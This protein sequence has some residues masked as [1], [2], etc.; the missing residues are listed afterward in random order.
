MFKNMKLRNKILIPVGLLVLTVFVLM[1]FLMLSHVD[2]IFRDNAFRLAEETAYRYG[3]EVKSALESALESARTISSTFEG[4]KKG[5]RIPDREILNQMLRHMLV[6]N[7]DFLGVWTCWEPYALDGRDDE[8]I[9]AE[10]HDHSGRYMPL[11]H[12]FS[13]EISLR[14][15]TGFENFLYT[16]DYMLVKNRGEELIS[17]PR[18][19]QN[20]EPEQVCISLATPVLHN[21]KV[22]AAAGIL[23][24]LDR[25][26]QPVYRIRPLDSGYISVISNSGI[27]VTHPMQEITGHRISEYVPE[28]IRTSLVQAVRR[29]E[30]FAFFQNSMNK[31][32][33]RD[34]VIL[35]P[36]PIGRT[37]TP[38]SLCVSVP[39]SRV[40]EN[41]ERL[42]Y[43]SFFV[44]SALLLSVILIVFFLSR[45]IVK[46]L[47]RLVSV[48]QSLADGNFEIRAGLD[49]RDE[50]GM[51]ARFI[52]R[53]FDIVVDKMYWYEGIVDAIPFPISVT[54]MDTRWTFINKKAEETV[55]RNRKEVL[56]LQCHNRNGRICNTN[57]CGIVL[58]RKG[59]TT[60]LFE[61]TETDRHYQIDTAWLRNMKGEKNGHVEIVQEITEA[62][63][64]KKKADERNWVQ[65]GES[66]F[67]HLIRG[68]QD[69]DTLGRNMISFLCKYI[70]AHV[71]VL[72]L[73]DE[74][75]EILKLRASYAYKKRKELS[76]EIRS[77]E[78]IAGQS[79]LEKQTIVLRNVPEDYIQV[80][81]GLGSGKPKNILVSP[82]LFDEE[83]KGV[84]EI[85]AFHEF[86][87][88]EME[89]VENIVRHIGVV[90]NTAQSRARMEKLLLQTQTQAEEL[91]VQQEELRQANEELEEQTRALKKSESSLQQ[92]QEELRVI[93][94][95]L[96]ERTYDL[97][98]QRDAIEKKNEALRDAH[99]EIELKARDLEIASKYK[100]EFLANMSHELRTPLNSILILSQL[101][102]DNRD[103]RLSPK[104]QEFAETIHSSGSDLLSL[105]NDILD[106]SKVE[107]G[108]LEMVIEEMNLVELTQDVRRT[109]EQV[110]EHKGL[111]LNVEM[112]NDL[113]PAIHTDVKRVW[114]I[115][116]NLLSNAFKF[117]EKGGVT[118]S[119]Y[120]PEPDTVFPVSGLTPENAL[121]FAVSDTGIGIPKD[122]QNLIFQAFQQADGTTSRKY[123]GTGLGLSISR[124]FAKALGGEIQ[125]ESE[126]DKGSSFILFLPVDPEGFVGKNSS[127][128]A[129]SPARPH[130]V[131]DRKPPLPNPDEPPPEFV[132][133]DR[134]HI[135]KGDKS[136]L[137]IEDDPN[138][139]RILLE[140][141]HERGF[142]V[143]VAEDGETGL[144]FADFYRPSG[145]ILDIA[146]PG[147]DGWSVMER[148]KQNPELRHIP[149]YFISVTD[150][151]LDALRLGAV[152]FLTKPVSMEMLED[153]FCRI[154][155]IVS[156][157]VKKLLVVED[158]EVQKK[159]I[160]ELVSGRDV[161]AVAVNT[162]EA[163]YEYLHRETV[164]CIILD[165]GLGDMSGYDFLATIRKNRSFSRIPVIV[166]TGRDISKDEEARLQKYA[167]SIIVKGVRSPERLLEETALFLHRVAAALPGEKRKMISAGHEKEDIFKDKKILIVDDDMRNVFALASVLEEKGMRIIE[168]RNG[169]ES[170]EKLDQHTDTDLVIMDIM[171]P[172]M[173]GYEAI[174][175]I[176]EDSRFKKLPIIA[177]TAK[178]M[179]GD[180]N[181][182]VEA[183]AN[184]YLAKPVDT[185]RL[186][187]LLRVWLY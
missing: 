56:G 52:D 128:K 19:Y 17:D 20:G 63:R 94:E 61:N 73:W 177:L 84:I 103:G 38:W 121:A 108:K 99:R 37:Q 183:G 43:L 41:S 83:L 2:G 127:R 62:R 117:T 164:D 32:K 143:L 9:N 110:A 105:I 118:L 8:F 160:M 86:S 180:K 97:E 23:I 135:C 51:A 111:N 172:E 65:T 55:G 119:I 85:G 64:L 48:S 175:R 156:R 178:A 162:G 75:K 14:V 101:L 132:T 4:M 22:I 154:E 33:E 96:E 147:I 28:N 152:G 47:Y 170:L 13:N 141:A 91:Q 79:A 78:G 153:V 115:M 113:P 18:K 158:E 81:S 131:Q 124:E 44:G 150:S 149:V 161:E 39:M 142:R 27:I 137:I 140:L 167:D 89:F 26:R 76:G 98:A 171:M 50:F 60:S 35:T 6:A 49:S 116:K 138:F 3:H 87:D 168:A 122:K 24:K 114:Q 95:E 174:G 25:I 36:F 186:L 66:R 109:F 42:R 166:Y 77:G 71:G 93:N 182:C 139:C 29:G 104:Q 163:A 67:N 106:L 68:D 184:D 80:E 179:K 134:R 90:V 12:R 126:P 144:H 107:A 123:G 45:Q 136:L 74:K 57:R 54:D 165:L 88:P 146:L 10:G 120:R 176:R 130:A 1:T 40:L 100:S 34:Y 173:D 102:S 11:W 145:I 72:Y 159:C 5:G 30:R 169:R 53:A 16:S 125:V 155:N 181:K 151:P 59:I 15:L 133:D 185:D 129:Q 58:L 7:P 31:G 112:E 21:E 92:Q 70:N 82:F 187:S 69:L 46:P 157:P 148:L